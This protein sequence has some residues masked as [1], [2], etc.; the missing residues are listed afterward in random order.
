[1]SVPDLYALSPPVYASLPGAT[2]A[3]KILESKISLFNA[4]WL[5][6]NT[7]GFPQGNR[8]ERWQKKGDATNDDEDNGVHDQDVSMGNQFEEAFENVRVATRLPRRDE[9]AFFRRS[10][11]T[12]QESFQRSFMEPFELSVAQSFSCVLLFDSGTFN[13]PPSH[14]DE[15]MAISSGD[16]LFIA[17]PLLSDPMESRTR[18]PKLKH[19]MGNI[20]RAG[21]A[22]LKPPDNPRIRKVGVEQWYFIS[23]ENWDGQRKDTFQDT[24]LHLWFTGSSLAIDSQKKMLG[25]KDVDL[26]MLESVV[27]IHGRGTT[28]CG[29]VCEMCFHCVTRTQS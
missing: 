24:S 15:I 2:L 6:N 21:T 28:E 13:V 25:E 14:M 3:I 12:L 9:S 7:A 27:S 5:P 19:I 11:R 1:M 8:P 20:G 4:Y 29:E 23:G 22:L 17:A 10:L 18:G 16:S 26:Y